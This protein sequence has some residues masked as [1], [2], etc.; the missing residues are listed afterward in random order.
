[1]APACRTAAAQVGF[2]VLN[3]VADGQGRGMQPA[4]LTCCRRHFRRRHFRR[5]HFRRRRRRRRW[6]CW[7]RLRAQAAQ[8]ADV[9]ASSN[10]KSLS[11]LCTLLAG[12]QRGASPCC[13][14][15]PAQTRCSPSR[16]RHILASPARCRQQQQQQQQHHGSSRSSG[17][18]SSR[19]RDQAGGLQ[20]GLPEH[21][22]EPPLQAQLGDAASTGTDAASF[23]PLLPAR[24]S[25]ARLH[26][27]SAPHHAPAPAPSPS[28][29][30]GCVGSSSHLP[31]CLPASRLQVYGL[32]EENWNQSA[33]SI[34]VVGASGDLA[35]KKIF[36]ALFALYYENMLPKASAGGGGARGGAWG[37]VQAAAA[38]SWNAA[39]LPACLL[40]CAINPPALLLCC[41]AHRQP[42]LF[43][44]ASALHL[45]SLPLSL[46]PRLLPPCRTSVCMGMPA[47]R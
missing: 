19:G 29:Q 14:P 12:A 33:L 36:P 35:K 24:Q 22:G 1:M 18:G 40:A 21:A 3:A 15:S 41:S 27:S 47:A 13:C 9:V 38:G 37:A 5:R 44:A 30:S 23:P 32:E 6:L 10:G 4:W 34:V 43:P 46:P 45:P 26:S 7:C 28:C 2:E 42:P 39:F 17:G 16:C 25:L 8:S 31:I 11:V 20:P